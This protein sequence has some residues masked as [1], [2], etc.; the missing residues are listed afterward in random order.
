[1]AISMY[2]LSVPVFERALANLAHVLERGAAHAQTVK[3]DPSVL[4]QARL[5]PDMF[6]LTKQVQIATD[7]AARGAARLA[8]REPPSLPDTEKSFEE[9]Q[10]R[11]EKARALVNEVRAQELEGAESRTI[12]FKSGPGTKKLPAVSYLMDFVLPNIYFHAATA[13]DILRHNG[14][15]LGKS[16]YLGTI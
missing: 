9:L 6:P 11:I 14:V 4:T 2:E 5:Y 1:M 12:E 15:V 13:Y 7:L 16:D 3:I 10:A 8:G